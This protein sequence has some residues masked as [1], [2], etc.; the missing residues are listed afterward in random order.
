MGHIVCGQRLEER[1]TALRERLQAGAH[2]TMLWIVGLVG[3]SLLL[4]GVVEYVVR[5]VMRPN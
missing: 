5:F 1:Y 2:V 4:T 3:G